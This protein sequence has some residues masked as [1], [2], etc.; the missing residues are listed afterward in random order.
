VQP[1]VHFLDIL[2]HVVRAPAGI[3]GDI[4]DVVPV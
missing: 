3:A 1:L 4:G 2:L